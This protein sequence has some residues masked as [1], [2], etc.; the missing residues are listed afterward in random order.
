[1]DRDLK[2]QYSEQWDESAKS[3]NKS[4][5]Y[6]WMCKKLE[7]YAVVLEIG[8]GTG[9]STLTLVESGHK[10][11]VV[12]NNE[13]CLEKTKRLLKMKGYTYGQAEDD[14]TNTDVILLKEDICQNSLSDRLL[15]YKIEVLA[16]WNIGSYWS[17]DMISK[18]IP[19]MVEYGLTL[20][21]I[22]KNLESSYSELVQWR[23]CKL[24]ADLN[25]CVHIID[26]NIFEITKKNDTY[27]I[28][29]KKEFDFKDINYDSKKT[30]S[31]SGGGRTLVKNGKIQT[32]NTINIILISVLIS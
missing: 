22:E 12:E 7:K 26:R 16:C 19:M 13:F 29:L 23:T 9:Y 21:Q 2:K 15:K 4:R 11:V 14:F 18:Y 25:V 3:F 1:M 28:S 24:G 8:C 31:K 5:D 27:F 10:V 20:P 30:V 32:A 6:A 17:E